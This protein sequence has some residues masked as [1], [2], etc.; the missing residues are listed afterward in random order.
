MIGVKHCLIGERIKETFHLNNFSEN[1]KQF[2][3]LEY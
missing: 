1:S 2:M 3:Y